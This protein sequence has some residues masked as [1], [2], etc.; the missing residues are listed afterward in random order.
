MICVIGSKGS[1][2]SLAGKTDAA[3]LAIVE[4]LMDNCLAGSTERAMPS[5]CATSRTG[6]GRSYAGK[7]RG[8]A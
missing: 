1:P 2:M 3:T 4:P 7:P 6:C 5:M 8:T